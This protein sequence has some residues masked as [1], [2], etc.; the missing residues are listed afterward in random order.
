MPKV[1]MADVAAKAGVSKTTVSRVLN[2]RP[3]VDAQTA[4]RVRSVMHELGFVPNA[5]AVSL[6]RGSQMTIGL[7]APSLS[8]PWML[9]VLRGAAAETELSGFSLLL[10]TLS[11]GDES[12]RSF[13]R[14]IES[15]AFD[16]VVLIEPPGQLTEVTD[17]L[18]RRRTPTV[19]IDDRVSRPAIP[20]VATTNHAGA[21]AAARHVASLGLE[22]IGVING[23]QDLNCFAERFAGWT[24]GLTESGLSVRPDLVID[25]GID[26]TG[27]HRACQQILQNDPDVQAILVSGDVPALGAL[28]CLRE[29]GRRVPDDVVVVGFDDIPAAAMATPS[30]STVHQPLF[31][32]GSA[33][34]RT[35]IDML[36]GKPPPTEPIVIPTTFIAREST[37]RPS[38]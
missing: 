30:L 36:A 3:D 20:S 6:A 21:L 33:A 4:D 16:A 25:A 10:H 29:D 15:N 34:V 18:D 14:Q 22:R 13:C 24:E 11:Q 23:P 8:W 38:R 28:R 26:E 9:E 19:L 12:L 32:M 37:R 17:V 35:A 1:T 5:G 31:E 7:L 27:G 2:D